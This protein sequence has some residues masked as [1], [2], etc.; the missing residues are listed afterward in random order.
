MNR[1]LPI[2]VLLTGMATL[3]TIPRLPAS[4]VPE[5]AADTIASQPAPT[6]KSKF[7]SGADDGTDAGHNRGRF[8][9]IRPRRVTG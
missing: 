3:Q 7:V 9:Q 2:L 6:G 4:T 5:A 1:M 8:A